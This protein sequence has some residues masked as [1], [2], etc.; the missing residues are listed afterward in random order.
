MS[1]LWYIAYTKLPALAKILQY[2]TISRS[3]YIS[4]SLNCSHGT[5]DITEN[6]NETRMIPGSIPLSEI[7]EMSNKD[8]RGLC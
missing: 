8:V 6:V 4:F 5:G 3:T 1:L 7:V 2:N